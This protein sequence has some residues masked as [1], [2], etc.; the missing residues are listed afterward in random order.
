MLAYML[1]FLIAQPETAN[2]SVRVE[3]QVIYQKETT[4]DLSG[5]N[6]EG[7]SALPSTFFLTKMRTPKADSLLNDRL[8]F[9]LKEYNRL[10][11]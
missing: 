4:V 10:G 1:L 7:D 11:F 8:Q 3:K 9:K 2:V 5:S 6:V